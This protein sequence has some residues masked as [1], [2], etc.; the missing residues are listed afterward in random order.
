[1][2][3]ERHGPEREHDADRDADANYQRALGEHLRRDRATAR[4]ERNTD[5]DLA[6]TGH[7]SWEKHRAEIGA[8]DEEHR[9]DG[10]EHEVAAE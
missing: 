1:M 3:Q 7:A 10:E 9:C 8:R 5:G 2:R 6:T 4:T